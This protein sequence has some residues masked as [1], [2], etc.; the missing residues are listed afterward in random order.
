[1]KPYSILVQASPEEILHASLPGDLNLDQLRVWPQ[2]EQILVIL[3]AFEGVEKAVAKLD[4]WGIQSFIGDPYNVCRRAFA[5]QQQLGGQDFAVRVLAIWKHLDLAYVDSMV[6]QMRCNPCDAVLV[7]R[8]FDVTFAADIA[9]LSVLEK[10]GCLEG[11][12]QSEARAKFNPWGYMDM[13][14]NQFSV[15]YAEPAPLYAATQRE[16][17]LTM[18][19]C[20]PENEFVGRDYAGSRYHFFAPMVPVGLRILDIACGSGEGA[21]LLSQQAEF[22]LGVDY[23]ESYVERARSRFPENDRLA[24]RVGDGQTFTF[25]GREAWFDLVV[26][27]HTLEHVPEDGKMLEN[28]A[29]NLKP[30]G[31]LIVE[32]PLLMP[33]PLGVPINPYHLREYQRDDFLNMLAEAGFVIERVFGVGRNFYGDVEQAR[34]AIHVHARKPVL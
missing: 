11:S 12:T 15:R 22:V 24:F 26:S 6:E 4:D 20:H 34:D 8:D 21:H 13:Y 10:I 29:R 27:L 33:R 28:L 1:M 2:I 30:G 7:P 25:E 32:V 19:R 17:L 18:P 23:L 31:L 9:S 14:S 16:A 3:P 5:A